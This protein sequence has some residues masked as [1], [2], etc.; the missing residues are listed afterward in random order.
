MG[1]HMDVITPA[2]KVGNIRTQQNCSKMQNSPLEAARQHS[3]E[4]NA[5]RN[6]TDR[7]GERASVHSIANETETPA[8]GMECIRTCQNGL[9][10]R[11]SPNTHKITMPKLT[12]HCKWVSAG[13]IIVYILLNAPIDNSSR[14]FVFGRVEGGDEVIVP[15]VEE[16]AGDGDGDRNRDDG[17]MDGTTNGDSIDSCRVNA[18][19]L[20]TESQ[21]MRYSQRTQI[22]NLPMS[23]WPPIQPA[24]R[25]HGHVR[26]QRRRGRLKVKTVTVSKAPKV[27]TIYLE[28]A[29][30][31]QPHGDDPKCSYGLYRLRCQHGQTKIAPITVSPMRNGETAYLRRDLIAQPCGDNPQRSYRVIGL[32]HRRGRLKIIPRNISRKHKERERLPRALQA[33]SSPSI[34]SG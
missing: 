6:L 22:G 11:N 16:R 34:R 32:R 10:S 14:M 28:R 5:C 8:N 13:G 26:W 21:H 30:A 31:M 9:K 17:N 33:H 29:C 2:D 15:N 20:A 1:I 19:Q 24:E 4:P 25:L 18:V 27:E 7:S 23:S 3:D 12:G